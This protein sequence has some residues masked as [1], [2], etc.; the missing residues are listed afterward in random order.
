MWILFSQ[1]PQILIAANKTLAILMICKQM[2]KNIN[3]HR[4]NLTNKI[5]LQVFP[6]KIK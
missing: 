5:I 2:C 3:N 1:I 4:T 6:N